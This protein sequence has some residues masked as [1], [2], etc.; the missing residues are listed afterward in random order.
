MVI[1][2][3][4]DRWVRCIY[5]TE[6]YV[7]NE[8]VCSLLLVQRTKRKLGKYFKVGIINDKTHLAALFRRLTLNL[9]NVL[10]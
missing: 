8:C 9:L 6:G 7:G 5:K 1:M 3:Y 10:S 4:P 2:K